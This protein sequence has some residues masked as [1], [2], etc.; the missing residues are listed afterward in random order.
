MKLGW[1]LGNSL[2][3]ND[4]TRPDTTVETAWG[5]PTVT[6]ELLAAVAAAGFG[7]VRIPVTWIGRFGAGPAHT[8]SPTF[9]ARV[10]FVNTLLRNCTSKHQRAPT[11]RGFE[12]DDQAVTTG[13]VSATTP[14]PVLL[15]HLWT[16]IAAHFAITASAAVRA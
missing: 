15:P 11:G 10:A 7:A 13:P 5:N 12:V 2:D 8:I 3:S 1:N 16:Q 9:L 4:P 6:P 14:K